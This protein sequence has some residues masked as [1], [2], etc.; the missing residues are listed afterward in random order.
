M[1]EGGGGIN[2]NLKILK[3]FSINWKPKNSTNPNQISS[4]TSKIAKP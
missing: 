3:L 2:M 1:E 4:S